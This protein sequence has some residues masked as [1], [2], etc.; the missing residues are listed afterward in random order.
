MKSLVIFVIILFL[1]NSCNTVDKNVDDSSAYIYPGEVWYDTDSVPI[2]AHAC[3][4]MLFDGTYYMYGQDQRLGHMNKTGVCCYSSKD[5]VNWKYE[6]TALPTSETPEVYQ[7]TG[8][9]ERPK[10]IYNEKTKK[11]VMWMHLDAEGYSMAEAGI[12]VSD[13]PVG[14]FKYVKSFRPVKYD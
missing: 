2:E 8:V 5:L 9:L 3:G 6:G 14:P 12:A 13:S 1:I 7:N 10:V 4:V 11:F